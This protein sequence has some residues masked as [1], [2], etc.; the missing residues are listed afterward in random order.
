MSSR[1]VTPLAIDTASTCHVHIV[2][3][4]I[5]TST[6]SHFQ[7]YQFE[8]KATLSLVEMDFPLTTT[9]LTEKKY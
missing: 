2:K 5:L 4:G 1:H 7:R 8:A 3:G 6:T 9:G